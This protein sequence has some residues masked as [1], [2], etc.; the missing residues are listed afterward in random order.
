MTVLEA[1][2]A[3]TPVIAARIGS[4]PEIVA[5]GAGLLFTP[6]DPSIARS[7]RWTT[8]IGS[9]SGGSNGSG[10][11]GARKKLYGRQPM[12]CSLEAI[13]ASVLN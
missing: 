12:Q 13:Y 10:R 1:F 2:A 9:L 11:S 5:E 7:S 3:G 6:G 8:D 4:L